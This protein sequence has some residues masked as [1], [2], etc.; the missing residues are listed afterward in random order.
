L[1]VTARN[2][3]VSTVVLPI[4]TKVAV[5]LVASIRVLVLFICRRGCLAGSLQFQ[6]IRGCIVPFGL[7]TVFLLH[8]V[9][10]IWQE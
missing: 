5:V 10:H 2:G 6:D 7:Y 1:V 3:V 4:A 8:L 9:P